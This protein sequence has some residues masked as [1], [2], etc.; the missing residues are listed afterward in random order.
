LFAAPWSLLTDDHVALLRIVV[1]GAETIAGVLLYPVVARLWG[2]RLAAALAVV[3]F[4]LVPLP[5]VV[6][7]NANMPN[8]FGQSAALVTIVCATVCTLGRAQYG[9]LAVLTLLT[10]LAFLSHVSTV[11][12][13]AATMAAMAGL[14]WWRGGPALRIPARSVLLAA[15]VAAG[16]AVVLYYGHFG[17]AYRT[18]ARVRSEA[19]ASESPQAAPRAAAPVHERAANALLITARDVG[20]PILVLM[21]I[22]LL[23]LR[24]AR[25]ADRLTLTLG[26]LALTYVVFAA[27]GAVVPVGIRYE[28]YAAEFVGRVD[29]ATYPAAVIAGAFGAAWMLRDGPATRVAGI[30]LIGL[31]VAVATR[32]WYSWIS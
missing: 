23:R 3:L 6:I 26:A 16:L 10:L 1:T 31:A 12:L 14:Y 2:D 7:G 18:L 28:R 24:S 11:S 25:R 27:F 13:L 30:A 5:Y 20:W 4:H 21:A 19:A 22:G 32:E 17:D 9:Q 29:L 8:A 15:I